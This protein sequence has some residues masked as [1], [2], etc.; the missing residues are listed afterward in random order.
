MRS[1]SGEGKPNR[2]AVIRWV[3][4]GCASL[5]GSLASWAVFPARMW[6]PT[7]LNTPHLDT[8]ALFGVSNEGLV[9]FASAAAVLLVC[10]LA[11]FLAS[12]GLRGTRSALGVLLL[13]VPIAA[14]F[15]FTYPGGAGDVFA[16]VAEADLLLAHGANPFRTPVAS[17]EGNPFLP[18]LDY[19]NET[20]HYGPVW[21]VI[22]AAVR[23]LAG[24]DLLASVLAF[25]VAALAGQLG[26]AW[27]AYTTLRNSAP[28]RA[29]TALALVAWNPLLMF[30]LAGNAHNDVAMTLFVIAAFYARARGGTGWAFLLLLAAVLV[31]YTAVILIPL[32]LVAE[33]RESRSGWRWLPRATIYAAT[34]GVIGIAVLALAGWEG[35]AGILDKMSTWFTTSAGAAVYHL[36]VERGWEGEASETVKNWARFA[37]TFIYLLE[38]RG[39]WIAPHAL[40]ERSLGATV[41]FLAVATVWFQPWYVTWV[42][43]LAVLSPTRGAAAIAFGA[44]AGGFLVHAVMGFGWRLEWNRD[45]TP[46]I[47]A[48]GTLAMWVP[49]LVALLLTRFRR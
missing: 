35:T 45:S 49:V 46:A 31:K 30:E 10:Y 13:A 9:S 32:F 37:F 26:I 29:A 15:L 2:S 17:V 47:H 42:V 21:L 23:T 22:A 38:L 3:V 16:Y 27:L 25:K 24:Q 5:V 7:Y 14:S 36:L 12:A 20:T 43:P 48:L 4:L 19:P 8:P 39:A 18:Y 40:V 34:A 41:A 28:G 11:A 1:A 33:W 44:T 6:L